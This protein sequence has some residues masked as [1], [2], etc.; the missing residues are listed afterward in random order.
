MN[1]I[2]IPKSKL[3]AADRAV[4]LTII[5]PHGA[6]RAFAKKAG[7]SIPSLKAASKGQYLSDQIID[8]IVR[9]I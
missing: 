5:K 2:Q 1:G 3:N 6:K 4:L 7:I 8:K 9:A